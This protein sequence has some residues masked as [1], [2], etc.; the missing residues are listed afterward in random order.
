MSVDVEGLV[1]WTKFGEEIADKMGAF[2]QQLFTLSYDDAGNLLSDDTLELDM[3][4][5]NVK[6]TMDRLLKKIKA[7]ADT[8]KEE[9]RGLVGQ[10][11]E[12][13]W[14]TT[15]LAKRIREHGDQMSKSRSE[16]IARTESATAYS[17]GSVLAYQD[18]GVTKKKW[19]AEADAPD[20]DCQ[21][22]GETVGVDES[23]S[24]GLDYPPAH[25][26]CRCAVAPVVE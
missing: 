14:S 7:V 26:N 12:E 13:G 4:N 17:A 11:T 3:S 20:D 2:Y 1:D 16:M 23:F 25:P 9:I 10:A 19:Q 6:K 22:D 24:N 21:I 5:P 15:E 18:A 8:T